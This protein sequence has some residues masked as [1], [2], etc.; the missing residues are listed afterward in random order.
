MSQRPV[1]SPEVGCIDPDCVN[2]KFTMFAK[3]VR[4]HG[5]KGF[6]CRL[7]YRQMYYHEPGG[8]EEPIWTLH[9]WG[10]KL[11][12]KFNFCRGC[13]KHRSVKYER[14][15]NPP[16]ERELVHQYKSVYGWGALS[17]P[18]WD[19]L[20][21]P[22]VEVTEEERE[23]FEAS[24]DDSSSTC[25]SSSARSSC[26]DSEEA[27]TDFTHEPAS[28][29][30]RQHVRPHTR[31]DEA[32][33]LAELLERAAQLADLAG[34]PHIPPA[35]VPVDAPEFEAFAAAFEPNPP[36]E[37]LVP[38]GVQCRFCMTL[39]LTNG[40]SPIATVAGSP[41]M[42]ARGTCAA[43]GGFMFAPVDHSLEPPAASV[44]GVWLAALLSRR[45]TAAS[46]TALRALSVHNVR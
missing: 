44:S 41:H 20:A 32:H 14:G 6:V 46:V 12:K 4:C 22:S 17:G 23:L 30:T 2:K 8:G 10:G 9:S 21:F 33:G 18:K 28:Y 42:P 24:C 27:E 38:S 13:F 45:N 3:R 19:N 39:P 5:C 40:D 7:H 37:P 43:H 34:L 25:T 15:L 1:N 11:N 29:N 16:V 31:H 26:Y 36:P 35:P